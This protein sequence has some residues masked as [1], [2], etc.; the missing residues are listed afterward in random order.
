MTREESH[1]TKRSHFRLPACQHL[2]KKYIR[3]ILWRHHKEPENFRTIQY[4]SRVS[5]CLSTQRLPLL[6]AIMRCLTPWC[7]ASFK[8]IFGVLHVPCDLCVQH[9]NS[10][11]HA[12][13]SSISCLFQHLHHQSILSKTSM[14]KQLP[15][16]H[17][18]HNPG[19]LN[20]PAQVSDEARNHSGLKATT[21]HEDA[22]WPSLDGF[23]SHLKRSGSS[24]L[25]NRWQ[26]RQL[27]LNEMAEDDNHPGSKS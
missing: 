13:W 2:P 20:T 18:A 15:L 16:R 9:H 24:C 3:Y 8:L 22:L 5:H 6:H 12:N 23:D 7:H 21:W 26:K 10:N 27:T 11:P 14:P 4:N 1:S 19:L 17:T 25:L